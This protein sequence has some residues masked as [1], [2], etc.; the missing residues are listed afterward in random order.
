ML[1][2]FA[3][4]IC[5]SADIYA[6]SGKGPES[7]IN[8]VTCHDGFTLNDLVSYCGKHNE[9]N[10]QNNHDG[11][12]DNYSQNNGAEGISTNPDIEALRSRLIKNFLLTLFI[13]RGV[14]M[15]LGGDEL[16]R[17]QAGNNNAYC[18]DNETSWFNWRNLDVYKEIFLFVR[19]M[20]AFRRNH[21]VLSEEKFYTDAEIAWFSPQGRLPNWA[22]PER[23]ELACLILEKE[24]DRLY[25]MF[26]SGNAAS[27]FT[28][29]ELPLNY[30]WHLSVDT[31]RSAPHDSSAATQEA[32]PIL[33]HT[34]HL[35]DRSSAVAVMRHL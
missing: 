26:N 22:D 34:Y 17:T 3:S 16:R 1:G 20:I 14:P 8:F 10:G 7:S 13:S 19:G 27:T 6:K 32:L 15:L 9:A 35:G 2:R 4:R 31:F 25:L 21:P 11:S 23:K 18:Q 33:S 29:P 28:L 5:G 30:F 24:Q 12:N